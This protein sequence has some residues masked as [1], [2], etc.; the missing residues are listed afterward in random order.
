[1]EPSKNMMTSSKI[2]HGNKQNFIGIP[3]VFFLIAV[4]KGSKGIFPYIIQFGIVLMLQEN[5]MV[6]FL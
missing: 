4:P 2:L 3:A 1:M 5:A 6:S